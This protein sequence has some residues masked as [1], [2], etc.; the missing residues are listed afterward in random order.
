MILFHRYELH[1]HAYS[2]AT[3]L[4]D[5]TGPHFAG[6]CVQQELN[7]CSRI[8]RIGSANI[9]STETEI[10]HCGDQALAGAA[11]SYNCACRRRKTWI[12]ATVGTLVYH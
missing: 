8:R 2:G 9:Q 3:P 5:S 10:L 4:H 11:P 7:Q 12:P 1:T 6:R